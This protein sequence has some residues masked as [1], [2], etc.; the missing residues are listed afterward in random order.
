MRIIRTPTKTPTLIP[1][2]L[3]TS[4]STIFTT[5]SSATAVGS[6]KTIACA[7]KMRMTMTNIDHED[8]REASGAY[9]DEEYEKWLDERAE[10]FAILD[11]IETAERA[12]REEGEW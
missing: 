9:R 6:W 4:A 10:E 1:R 8:M 3:R 2:S 5:R 7:R 11:E 12:R